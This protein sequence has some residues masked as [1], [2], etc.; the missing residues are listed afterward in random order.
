M[1]K[2][3]NLQKKIKQTEVLTNINYSFE[4]GKI[5]GVFGK[6]GSGK[7][8]LLRSLAGLIIPTSGKI[9]IDDKELHHDI[10]FPPSMGIIIEN[11]EL[12][13]Q[14]DAQTNL[15]I[16]SKIKNIASAEDIDNAIDRVGLS[17]HID[18]KVKKYS[19]GMK[20]RLNIAQA[21]FEKPAVILL[22]EPTN[23]IDDQGIELINQLLLEEKKRGATI[24][25]AS[26]HKED[27]EPLCDMS[28]RMD[29]GKI[30]HD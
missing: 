29:Q 4:P 6:N 7:T 23:A 9:F 26:H 24:I 19:L 10:S 21:I 3:V 12:L 22:D 17:P 27:I 13:P 20:Q 14:F 8:M 2:I 18:K 25:I 16:L 28:I 30:I 1:I 11:M 15:K 5:Y